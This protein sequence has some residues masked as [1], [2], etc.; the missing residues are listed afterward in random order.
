MEVGVITCTHVLS[1]Q[2]ITQVSRDWDGDIQ[3]LCSGQHNDPSEGRIMCLPEML[4]RD[5]SIEQALS[6][7]S[8]GQAA[9]RTRAGQ[10]WVVE[11]IPQDEA[12]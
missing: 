6:A 10:P 12:A 9:Y 1:G 2:P 5:P 11:P 8:I 3:I 4:A 7:L